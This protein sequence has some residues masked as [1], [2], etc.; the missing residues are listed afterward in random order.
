MS[1]SVCHRFAIRASRE[2]NPT[3]VPGEE[4]TGSWELRSWSGKLPDEPPL[5]A[6][7]IHIPQL[8]A[9]TS[10][11]VSATSPDQP[12]PAPEVEVPREPC[13]TPLNWV[14]VVTSVVA[15]SQPISVQLVDGEMLA[16]VYGSGRPLYFIG[17]ATGNAKL[18][19]LTAYLLKDEFTCVMIDVPVWTKAPTSPL[20]QTADAIRRLADSLGHSR[21][22]LYAAGY[23]C[24]V[25]LTL[26]KRSPDRISHL[27]LQGPVLREPTLQRERLFYKIGRLL[28][29]PMSSLPGWSKVQQQNHQ[30]YFPPFD[31]TR[32]H[33]LLDSLGATSVRQVAWRLLAGAECDWCDLIPEIRQPVM[34]I[35]TEGEGET[36]AK[37][38]EEF[39]ADLP[40]CRTEW[41]PLAGH[42][43]Y[44]TH[45]NRLVKVIKQYLNPEATST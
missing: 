22:D 21:F 18:F 6:W 40:G 19:A 31:P 7:R 42:Y 39:A 9:T 36:L 5:I 32:Y 45:P 3:L 24:H 38:S 10:H 33:F 43:P 20:E 2:L 14:D 35:R 25:A 30:G 28:T 8:T 16:E 44:L 12:T 23:G 27:M 29:R 15:E 13:P 26:M 1:E 4:L 34:V 17:G 37:L 11:R 41:M